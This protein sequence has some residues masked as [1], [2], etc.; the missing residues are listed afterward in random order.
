MG[1]DTARLRVHLMLLCTAV[2]AGIILELAL[3]PVQRKAEVQ[4]GV[5]AVEA[6]KEAELRGRAALLVLAVL[7]AQPLTLAQG[8]MDPPRLA[9]VVA[10]KQAAERELLVKLS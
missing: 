10:V 8:Q 3:L 2:G 9:A 6:E 1:V 5:A 7:A 4:F